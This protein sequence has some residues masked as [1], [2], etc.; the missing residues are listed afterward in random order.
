MSSGCTI[1]RY[2]D[3]H[4]VAYYNQKHKNGL[5]SP[6]QKDETKDD[7]APAE[8]EGAAEAAPPGTAEA[9]PTGT[10][11]V[12]ETPEMT[13]S[14]TTKPSRSNTVT[15]KSGKAKWAKRRMSQSP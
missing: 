10:V 5:W 15:G 9:A 1:H 11:E 4:N 7:A 14:V 2:K 3:G 12:A 13:K 8:V 6:S